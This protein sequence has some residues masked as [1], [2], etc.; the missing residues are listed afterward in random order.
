[1]LYLQKP[2]LLKV[3][4]IASYIDHTV[5]KPSTTIADVDRICVEASE[6]NFAAVCVPPK[7]V[8]DAK[9]LLKGSPIKVLGM[10]E[11]QILE[12]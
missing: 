9:K 11:G 7:F 6:E 2:I 1:M 10:T 4:N 3:F 8:H 12:F 5:L